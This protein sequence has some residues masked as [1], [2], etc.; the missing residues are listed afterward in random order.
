ML[1][2]SSAWYFQQKLQEKLDVAPKNLASI[3]AWNGH[4]VSIINNQTLNQQALIIIVKESFDYLKI[5]VNSTTLTFVLV[6]FLSIIVSYGILKISKMK[7]FWW[8]QYLYS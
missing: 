7:Q 3:I 2:Y 6:I 5:D 4:K 8:L 1:F